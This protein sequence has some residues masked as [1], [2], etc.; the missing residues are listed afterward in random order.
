M[1]EDDDDSVSVRMDFRGDAPP[2]AMDPYRDNVIS[3][4]QQS[5]LNELRKDL[6]LDDLAYLNNHKEVM[7]IITMIIVITITWLSIAFGSEGSPEL[8]ALE[9]WKR[10][11]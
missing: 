8:I 4:G 5:I 10:E 9:Y 3:D 7:M 11:L 6:C 2:T 1:S